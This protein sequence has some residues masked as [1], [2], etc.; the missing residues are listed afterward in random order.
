MALEKHGISA[1][2][3]VS[4]THCCEHISAYEVLKVAVSRPLEEPFDRCLGGAGQS[5]RR[6]IRVR[7]SGEPTTAV[8]V[9]ANLKVMYWGS[10]TYCPIKL[11]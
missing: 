7:S 11:T 4:W 1:I 6:Q 3:L 9:H 10:N 8:Y 5:L 2:Y